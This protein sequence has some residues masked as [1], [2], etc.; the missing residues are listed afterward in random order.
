MGVQYDANGNPPVGTFDVENRLVSEIDASTGDTVSWLYDPWGKRVGRQDQTTGASQ[1]TLYGVTGQMLAVLACTSN[2]QWSTCAT[3]NSNVYFK[4]RLLMKAA[5]GYMPADRLGSVGTGSAYFP[6]GEEQASPPTPTGVERFG[7][8]YRDFVGQDYADQR[9]YTSI[10]GR[11]LTPD[12]LFMSAADKKDP[13]S[14]NRYVYAG[15]DPVNRNDP[16]GL[17]SWMSTG[18][19]TIPGAPPGFCG[20]NGDPSL[21]FLPAEV[22]G[23]MCP[24]YVAAPIVTT[25]AATAPTPCSFS[26]QTLQS[27]MLNTPAYG[28]NGLPISSTT[29]ARPLADYAST[30]MADAV[31]DNVDPR[32]LVAIA[33]VETKFGALNCGGVANTNNP[34]CLGG[35][36]PIN[37]NS[38]T[39]AISA[40]ANYLMARIGPTTTVTDLYNPTSGKKGYCNTAEC[41]ATEVNKRL[42]QQ[43]GGVGLPGVYGPL[44]S[45]CY[46][47]SGG[48]YY[49]KQ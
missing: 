41:A 36:N 15:D 37:Y 25:T 18:Q 32:L 34:F 40:A 44:Q 35:K 31:A 26:A 21:A 33:F 2:G 8:Y 29:T 17:D 20:G 14:W 30:I 42:T 12:P 7:T 3:A 27:Y 43:G 22:A 47:G 6:Y 49:Q 9:Y 11:F 45:P 48:N 10:G 5:G 1:Y 39:D 38:I 19:W 28:G 23:W 4:G 24:A 13:G 16:T 46:L